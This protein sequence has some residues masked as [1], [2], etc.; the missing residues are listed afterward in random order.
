MELL[1]EKNWHFDIQ[2]NQTHIKAPFYLAKPYDKLHIYFEYTPKTIADEALSKRIIEDTLGHY[3]PAEEVAA[4]DWRSFMPITNLLT[5]SLDFDKTYVGAA[6]RHPP[7]QHI[8]ISGQG[9]SAGF[10]PQAVGQGHWTATI[11]LHAISGP[12]TCRLRA[13]GEV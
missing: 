9:S 5:L 2:H 11:S 12:V 4:L 8:E 10:A 1:C 6:H 13:M 7:K 3:F